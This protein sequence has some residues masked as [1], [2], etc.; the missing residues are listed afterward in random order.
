MKPVF[1]IIENDSNESEEEI[2]EDCDSDE[3]MAQSNGKME[4]E[5]EETNTSLEETSSEKKFKHLV[6]KQNLFELLVRAIKF[7]NE[8]VYQD[9]NKI[10]HIYES[11]KFIKTEACDAYSLIFKMFIARNESIE[12]LNVEKDLV[13]LLVFLNQ[14][15]NKDASSQEEEKQ[16]SKVALKFVELI[17]DLYTSLNNQNKLSMESKPK[18]VIL[19][20]ELINKYKELSVDLTARLV[21]ILG[22]IAIKERDTNIKDGL[23]IIQVIIHKNH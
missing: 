7:D 20:Q 9:A 6:K 3:E 19:C 11:I 17:Y 10:E 16:N 23:N 4:V 5:T 21:K 12:E 14:N 2:W 22:M 8:N 15:F 13:D 1:F 18:I